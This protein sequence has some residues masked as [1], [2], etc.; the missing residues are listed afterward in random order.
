M[1]TS[2]LEVVSLWLGYRVGVD[3]SAW[4]YM[5]MYRL[6]FGVQ[7]ELI[8][9]SSRPVDDLCMRFKQQYVLADIV[10]NEIDRLTS[11]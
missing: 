2:Q 7:D 4:M 3:K 6:L 8:R 10:R 1:F 9:T 5:Y 11:R